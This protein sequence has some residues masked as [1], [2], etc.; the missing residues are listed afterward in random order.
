MF[1]TRKCPSTNPNESCRNSDDEHHHKQ[2]LPC[3]LEGCKGKF[4]INVCNVAFT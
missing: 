3:N 1:R 4:C 2:E